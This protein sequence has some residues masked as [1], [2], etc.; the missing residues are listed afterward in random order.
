M[1]ARLAIV[2]I[3]LTTPARADQVE[4]GVDAKAQV[5]VDAV[6]DR[7]AA[8]A[9]DIER[10][11]KGAFRRARRAVS[12]GPTAGMFGG[13]F[14]DAEQA[15][16]AITFGVGVELFKVPILPT[17]ANIKA[18]VI[19]RAKDKLKSR[20]LAT[21]DLEQIVRDA[22]DEAIRE[23]FGM[24]GIRYKTMEKPRLSLA[25]EGNRYLDS[26]VW[27][28][29]FRAG[30]GISKVTLAA[31]FATAFTDPKTS[32]FTGLE[33]VTHFLLA[34]RPRSSVLDVFVRADFEFRNRDLANTDFYGVG[35]RY[36]LDAF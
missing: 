15:D 21:G 31:S 2:T 5:N 9:P 24:E 29:R 26:E 16:A 36:L 22:W 23:L 34:K 6:L 11:A 35:V 10:I 1:L 28:V 3:L 14:L 33:I 8:S 30:I 19:E 27:A 18:L 4:V 13:A 20:Q 32:V 12:V 25:L 7:V 17:P